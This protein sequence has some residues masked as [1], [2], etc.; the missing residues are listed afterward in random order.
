[1][2][3]SVLLRQNRQ[4]FF[5]TALFRFQ[6]SC[7]DVFFEWS[8]VVKIDKKSCYNV[9]YKTRAGSR[10]D[11]RLLFLMGGGARWYCSAVPGD[12]SSRNWR[13][14]LPDRSIRPPCASP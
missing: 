8:K 12:A 2:Y 6:G 13:S 14:R 11:G 3:H 4:L 5:H 9:R 1:M 7:E 10:S